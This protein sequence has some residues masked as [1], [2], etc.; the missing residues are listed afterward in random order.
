ME[1]TMEIR[2]RQAV[3]NVIIH[4]L[5]NKAITSGC[6]VISESPT[7]RQPIESKHFGSD[8]EARDFFTD[9]GQYYNSGYPYGTDGWVPRPLMAWSVDNKKEVTGEVLPFI[10]EEFEKANF[11]ASGKFK[12][13]MKIKSAKEVGELRNRAMAKFQEVGEYQLAMILYYPLKSAYDMKLFPSYHEVEYRL[14]NNHIDTWYG[15]LD[16]DGQIVSIL[17]LKED[18]DVL[19]VFLPELEAYDNMSETEY[20]D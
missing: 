7:S 6:I 16:D 10:N 2:S 13:W 15:W 12:N 14:N 18:K 11:S 9:H 19:Y 8:E 5:N 20:A 1:T 4:T 17:D 3:Q